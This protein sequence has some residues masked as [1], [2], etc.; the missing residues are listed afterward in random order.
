MS[1]V[2]QNFQDNTFQGSL[3][4]RGLYVCVLRAGPGW[5]RAK[6]V[7]PGRALAWFSPGLRPR[8]ENSGLLRPLVATNLSIKKC[9]F[10]THQEKIINKKKH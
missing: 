10:F 7:G 9:E 4:I 6:Y 8:A 5:P 3:G 2:S 1:F